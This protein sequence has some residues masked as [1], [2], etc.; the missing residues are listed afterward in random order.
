MKRM[1]EII[2]LAVFMISG[3]TSFVFAD[4]GTKIRF[5]NMEFEPP[6]MMN[7]AEQTKDILVLKTDPSIP[8]AGGTITLMA[9]RP[10]KG[11][12]SA[13]F[14]A[15]WQKLTKGKKLLKSEP[16]EETELTDG[17]RGLS[18][19][20]Q[21]PAG[22]VFTLS[23][24]EAPKGIN[25]I[26]MDAKDEMAA[27]MIGGGSF[28]FL[29]SLKLHP[30]GQA[31]ALAQS[32]AT[33]SAEADRPVLKEK[34]ALPSRPSA[35]SVTPDF[36]RWHTLVRVTAPQVSSA[37]VIRVVWFPNDDDSLP[38]A[39]AL[40][41]ALRKRIDPNEVEIE[42]PRNA[43]GPG[44][45]VIRILAI[46]PKQL[47]PVFIARFTVLGPVQTGQVRSLPSALS[48]LLPIP[49]ISEIECPKT[50]A[51]PMVS[52]VPEI[53]G[54]VGGATLN[55]TQAIG[56]LKDALEGSVSPEAMKALD[57]SPQAKD[58][59]A[60]TGVAVGA[61][62]VQ[63]P[64]ATVAYLIKAHETAPNEPVFLANLSGISNYVGLHR[65][66]LAFAQ[67]AESLPKKL[68]ALQRAVLLSNKG[69]ALNSLG[70]PK[71]A[72][73]VL[74]EAIHLA[75]DLSEAYNNI[76]YSL[77]DQDKCEPAARFLRAG[78]TRQPA[79]VYKSDGQEP[80][81]IPLPQV[82]DMSKGKPGV[83]P[84]VP[85]ASDPGEVASVKGHLNKLADEARP[86]A[87]SEESLAQAIGGMQAAHLKWAG[88]GAEGTL[89]QIFAEALRGAF[90][91]YTVNII[92]FHQGWLGSAE[93]PNHPDPEIR[94]TANAVS[95]ADKKRIENLHETDEA[96][97]QGYQAAFKEFNVAMKGCE[98]L[99]DRRSCDA[100]A[101]LTRN[102]RVCVLGKELSGKRKKVAQ[103]YDRALR[104]LYKESYRRA[105]ALAANF[106]EPA[107]VAYTRIWLDI[108]AAS[109]LTRLISG[110]AYSLEMLEHVTD[111]CKAADTTPMNIMFEHLKALMKECEE[112]SKS[113][114]SIAALEISANCE[115][116]EIGASTPG[117][118]GLFGQV[119]YKFS[120]RFRRITDP[121]E[122]FL[123]KQAGRDPDVALNLPDYDGA[124]DGELT[125][126]AGVQAKAS[127]HDV[128]EG[129]VKFGGTTTWDGRGNVINAGG[130]FEVS[131]SAQLGAAGKVMEVSGS[132]QTSGRGGTE[133][134]G[135]AQ[136]GV[137]DVNVGVE[138]PMFAAR[139]GGTD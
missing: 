116:I 52:N 100:L 123:T 117:A 64:L 124:F 58:P 69:Y 76:A 15:E 60:A 82:I 84:P 103:A 75:P 125:I 41:A 121:K 37:D 19:S 86:D 102:T 27:Q 13:Q 25:F 97:S 111:A 57:A 127:L 62:A 120:Q 34:T 26:V 67:K 70:R 96:W 137:A 53:E 91:D 12:L 128:V 130:K 88:Q 126:T 66:A 81:R 40:P 136:A 22:G 23:V 110:S 129:G 115:Q 43:G 55:Y 68:P 83:L 77:G 114:A 54:L 113:K 92:N 42:I 3:S 87:Q 35:G 73:A 95:E 46:M 49:P 36:G 112:S 135:S 71:E 119:G 9:G 105:S 90:D 32:S 14:D 74:A 133:V 85:Y 39:G 2:L 1:M 45:G 139:H 51:E 93:H 28:I 65:E 94:D 78:N 47:Q 138:T 131:G 10:L 56:N 11:A 21:T 99:R 63:K 7:K 80:T 30:V 98:K 61:M 31:T 108:Y 29:M 107:H 6:A 8:G 89:T 104:E 20:A 132:V 59:V 38:Q 44:G 109:A 48:D 122:R 106:S 17:S 79:Y 101:Y 4:T 72:E 50:G 24:Y 18:R 5:S 134:S 16:D 118:V 33:K